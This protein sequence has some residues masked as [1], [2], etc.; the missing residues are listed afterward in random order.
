MICT[1]PFLYGGILQLTYIPNLFHTTLVT[2]RRVSLLVTED[3]DRDRDRGGSGEPHYFIFFNSKTK[4][5]RNY[6]CK[7]CQPITAPSA[8]LDSNNI[9]S[10][11]HQNLPPIYG[12][13]CAWTH[14]EH[15]VFIGPQNVDNWKRN[16]LVFHPQTFP[17]FVDS[18]PY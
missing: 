11:A 16:L 17:N 10:A 6:D 18:G 13:K 3:L 14:A 4:E 1:T 15:Q 9:T 5:T 7:L 2:I 12:V 8:S